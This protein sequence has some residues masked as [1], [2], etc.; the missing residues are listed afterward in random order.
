MS[1]TSRKTLGGKTPTKPRQKQDI[2]IDIDIDNILFPKVNNILRH[3][4]ARQ[5]N[6]RAKLGDLDWG[7]SFR[8]SSIADNTPKGNITKKK[9]TYRLALR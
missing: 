5:H 6:E 9:G 4:V 7:V 8:T 1:S 2:D 3:Y